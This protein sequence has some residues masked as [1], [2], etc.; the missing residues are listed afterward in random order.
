MVASKPNFKIIV[1]LGNPGKE[2]KNTYHNVGYLFIDD[3]AKPEK[4]KK[5]DAFLY[6]KTHGVILA[7]MGS[8]MNE[9]GPQISKLLKYFKIKKEDLLI[10]HDD[11][12][13]AI[14][15]YK[16]SFGRSSAG[17]NGAESIIKSLETADIYRL[18]IGIRNKKG[19]A[20]SFVLKE[21]GRED[22]TILGKIFLEIQTLYF[23][24]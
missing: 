6:V 14:G 1:G 20:G 21:I 3:F 7:K 10:V 2:Y 19:K 22:K 11:S 24:V 4:F 17:H 12:D 8:Y 15:K 13:I 9:S 16:L 18:R 23:K 5:T